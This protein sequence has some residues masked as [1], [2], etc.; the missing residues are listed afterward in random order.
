MSH[1]RGQL[2]KRR[3]FLAHHDL[4]LGIAQIFQHRLQLLVLALEFVRQLLHQVQALY[5]NGM[6]AEHLERCRHIGHFVLAADIHGGFEIAAGHAPHP[7]GQLLEP[8]QQHAPDKQPGDQQGA[9][10]AHGADGQQHVT[11]GEDRIL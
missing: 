10:H 9:A 3:E 1:A 7:P 8:E 6:A 5:F 11:A 4:I 2:T